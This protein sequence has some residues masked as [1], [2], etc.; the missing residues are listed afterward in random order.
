VVEVEDAS[1]PNAAPEIYNDVICEVSE[2]QEKTSQKVSEAHVD[3][4]DE[5]MVEQ[6]CEAEH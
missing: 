1:Q 3:A 4:S 6:S 5:S 2:S